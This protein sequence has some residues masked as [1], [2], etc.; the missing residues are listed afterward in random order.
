MET[1]HAQGRRPVE[2]CGRTQPAMSMQ[3]AGH[4]GTDEP[5]NGRPGDAS[6]PI[7]AQARVTAKGRHS[8]KDRLPERVAKR[9]FAVGRV[10][11]AKN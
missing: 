4:G 5:G 11:A 2:Q 6:G 1:S 10:S 3:C 9:S 8:R 7:I